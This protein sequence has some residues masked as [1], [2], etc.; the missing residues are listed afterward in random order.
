[1]QKRLVVNALHL[2]SLLT[3]SGIRVRNLAAFTSSHILERGMI[4]RRKILGR[5][6]LSNHIGTHLLIQK[7][8]KVKSDT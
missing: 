6:I 5:W 2:M 8:L 1:M 3:G 7:Q 4:T